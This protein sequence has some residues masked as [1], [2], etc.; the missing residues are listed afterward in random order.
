MT[1]RHDLS[2][3]ISRPGYVVGQRLGANSVTLY[4]VNQYSQMRAPVNT[5]RAFLVA[6]VNPPAAMRP[7]YAINLRACC[8]YGDPLRGMG[9]PLLTD[10][11]PMAPFSK[12][13]RRQGVRDHPLIWTA[14]SALSRAR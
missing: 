14:C 2:G 6:F 11:A 3:V 10:W 4:S 12:R 1:P 13:N 8:A 5:I 7:R 9:T